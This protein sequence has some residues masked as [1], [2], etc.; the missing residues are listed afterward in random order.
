MNNRQPEIFVVTAKVTITET[1]PDV[2]KVI[3]K[4]LIEKAEDSTLQKIFSDYYDAKYE[5]HERKPKNSTSN[6]LTVL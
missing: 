4:D 3:L 5:N 6:T 2:D 1:S